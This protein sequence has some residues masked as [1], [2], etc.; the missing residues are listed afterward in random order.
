MA[1]GTIL[2]VEDNH[3]NLEIATDLLREAGFT[4]LAA[5]NAETA[6]SHVRESKPDLILLDLNLPDKDGYETCDIIRSLPEYQGAPIVAFTAMAMAEEQERAARHGC[7]GIISKPIDV[8]E[9]ANMVAGYLKEALPENVKPQPK[10]APSAVQP[11]PVHSKAKEHFMS[12]LAHDLRTPVFSEY[13]ALQMLVS[14]RAGELNPQ[15]MKLVCDIME[16]NRYQHRLLENL[17]HIYRVEEG[18]V[19][20]SLQKLAVNGLVL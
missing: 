17:L 3:M 16:A 8:D 12:I 19:H 15:Q 4:T 18:R 11:A 9:F 6:L 2:V 5:E 10:P 7:S 13:A 14:G 1:S 20:P